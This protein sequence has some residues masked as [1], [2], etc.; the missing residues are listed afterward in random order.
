M[1]AAEVRLIRGRLRFGDSKTGAPFPSAVVI[2]RY[3]YHTPVFFAMDARRNTPLSILD[4]TE[5]ADAIARE[6]GIL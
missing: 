4:D 5:D 2:F 3:G 6:L 1:R